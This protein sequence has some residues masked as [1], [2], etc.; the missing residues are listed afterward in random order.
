MI[1]APICVECGKLMRPER[2]GVLVELT[3]GR[4]DTRPY[5]LYMADLWQCPKC[6]KQV[7]K[8]SGENPLREYFME[9]YE[10]FRDKLAEHDPLYVIDGKLYVLRK[11]LNK[12]PELESETA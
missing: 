2:N 7:I 6:E 10:E 12:Y 8:G 11:D 3:M 5:Q 4:E 1:T 9:D